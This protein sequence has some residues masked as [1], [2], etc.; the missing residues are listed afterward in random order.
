[1]PASLC[2]CEDVSS[3]CPVVRLSVQDSLSQ[4]YRGAVSIFQRNVIL[5]RILHDERPTADLRQEEYIVLRIE[6]NIVNKLL[7]VFFRNSF[8]LCLKLIAGK[9]QEEET[10]NDVFIF[11]WLDR[12]TEFICGLPQSFLH[13]N[14]LLRCRCGS[15]HIKILP[16]Y[17]SNLFYKRAVRKPDSVLVR[18]HSLTYISDVTVQVITNAQQNREGHF[19]P[20][21]SFVHVPAD[22]PTSCREKPSLCRVPEEA[23]IVS[24]SLCARQPPFRLLAFNIAYNII[25]DFILKSN[26]LIQKLK[27]KFQFLEPSLKDAGHLRSTGDALLLKGL[28]AL[29]AAPMITVMV[30]RRRGTY[31]H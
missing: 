14:L 11:C 7:T 8:P 24:Y 10:E 5:F 27:K 3:S 17:L 15:C 23:S 19:F 29:C 26:S 30:S 4:S 6:G 13:R 20:L 25:L 31:Q 18:S 12:T 1:M 21:F 9:L 22:N 16:V 28:F 2:R